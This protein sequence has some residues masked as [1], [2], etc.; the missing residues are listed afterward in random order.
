M[1]T[2]HYTKQVTNSFFCLRYLSL[3]IAVLFVLSGC[4]SFGHRRVPPDRFNYNEVLAESS[5]EQMLLNIIRLRYLEEPVFLVVSSILTQYVY[6]VGAGVGGIFDLGGGSDTASAGANVGYEER[7]T[8]TYLPV[9]GREFS[10]HLL[11]SIPGD[12]FFAAAQKGWD[13]DIL[14][15]IG[16]Q[17][18]G[19]V[20]NMS[21]GAIPPPGDLD[22]RAQF[23][24]DLN[25]LKRFQHVMR[26]LVRLSDVEAY[27]VRMVEKNDAKEHHLIFSEKIPEEFQ[28]MAKELRQLLELS[29]R[30][31]FRF[32][33]RL[34]DTEDDEISIQTRSVLAMMSFLSRGVEVPPEHLA[35]GRVIDYRFPESGEGSRTDLIPFKVLWSKQRPDKSFAA[36]RY[37]DYWFYIDHS[38]INSKRSLGLIIALFRLQ[39]PDTSGVAP[40]L[41]VPTGG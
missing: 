31:T 7:P 39:A 18:I 13:V 12:F 6:D 36:V 37:Q 41:T 14:M 8:I 27:E 28:P 9:E 1:N 25:K 24:E 35:E 26:L 40:V 20:E 29:N 10:A 22:L 34:T 23:Q 32:T 5:R 11:S 33:D 3:I 15:Q 16:L 30:N 17:R 21:F 2:P 19:A 38:D 4:A